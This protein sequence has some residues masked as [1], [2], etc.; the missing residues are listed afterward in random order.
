MKNKFFGSSVTCTG[1]LCGQDI[2]DA[3]KASKI[4]YDYLVIPCTTLKNDED[5]FLDGVTLEKMQLELG[6][7]EVTDGSGQ[8]FVYALTKCGDIYE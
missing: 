7:V 4:E 5:V 6:K 8:S 3:V 2:I 1:L